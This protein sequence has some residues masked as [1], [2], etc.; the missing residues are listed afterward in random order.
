MYMVSI[1]VIFGTVYIKH[2]FYGKKFKQLWSRIPSIST[3]RTITSHLELTEHKKMGTTT[4][5]V[6]N[7][8]PD[9]GQAQ[10]FGGI[11]LANGIPTLPP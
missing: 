1:Q 8:G 3:K 4:Y 7:A 10:H 11:K 9:L 6:G 5:D 2:D